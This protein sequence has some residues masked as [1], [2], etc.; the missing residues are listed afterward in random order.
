MD[1]ANFQ[2]VK[3]RKV[4]SLGIL[5]VHESILNHDIFAYVSELKI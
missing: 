2:I 5:S 3:K 1:L 4:S